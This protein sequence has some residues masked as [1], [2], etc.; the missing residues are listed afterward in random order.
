MIGTIL[1][2]IYAVVGCG[3]CGLNMAFCVMDILD[4]RSSMKYDK[5]ILEHRMKKG[6]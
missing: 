5:L 6:W 4:M 3:F 1:T 2:A